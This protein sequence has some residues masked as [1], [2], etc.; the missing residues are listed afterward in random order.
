MIPIGILGGSSD[1]A[2]ADYYRRI[3][4]AV[5]ARL[6]GAN[7]GEVLI[8]SMNFRRATDAVHHGRWD[9]LGAYLANRAKALE[10]AGAG[11]LLC[12]SNTLH[13]LVPEFTMG[14]TIP[15]LHIVDPTAVAIR[16]Q[17]LTRVAFLGTKAA[18]SGGYLQC[19]YA[20][21][22]GVETVMPPEDVQDVMDRIIFEELC[23]GQFT[24]ASKAYY[25]DA[26]SQMHN[27]GVQGVILGCTEIPLLVSQYDLLHVPM[28]DTAGLHVAAAVDFSLGSNL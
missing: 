9:E 16:T 18:M 19:R 3:N 22:F 21:Q 6:G 25:L 8:N 26:I 13:R 23:K 5:N 10:S 12:V 20:E 27:A 4:Q 15:F 14:L 28:F 1:Q 24:L 2:T 11:I 7:T 17:G